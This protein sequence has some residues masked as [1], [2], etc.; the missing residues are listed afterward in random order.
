MI[1]LHM[2]NLMDGTSLIGESEKLD[3]NLE[4]RGD[5]VRHDEIS[6]SSS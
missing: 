5:I 4:S 2:A 6:S 3:E 1:R